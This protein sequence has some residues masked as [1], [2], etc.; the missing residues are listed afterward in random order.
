[1]P[2]D[3]SDKTFLNNKISMVI[4]NMMQAIYIQFNLKDEVKVSEEF[5]FNFGWAIGFVERAFYLNHTMKYGRMPSD[6]DDNKIIAEIQKR[7]GEIRSA[8]N[9]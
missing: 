9:P 6:E 1:M 4:D 2:F 5:D 3:S 8:T 7:L